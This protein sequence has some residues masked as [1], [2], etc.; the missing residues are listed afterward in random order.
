MKHCAHVQMS[1]H[2][3]SMKYEMYL[4][5]P[6]ALSLMLMWQCG[7]GAGLA[8]DGCKTPLVQGIG[9]HALQRQARLDQAGRKLSQRSAAS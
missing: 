6:P 2:R 9:R 5:S 3:P 8:A 4:P 1:K 7:N